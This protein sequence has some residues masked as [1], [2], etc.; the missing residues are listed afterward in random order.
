MEAD[1]GRETYCTFQFFKRR[2]RSNDSV[3]VHSFPTG[4]TR[5]V[6]LEDLCQ[7]DV[8]GDIV[9]GSIGSWVYSISGFFFFELCDAAKDQLSIH[10]SR[11][12]EEGSERKMGVLERV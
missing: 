9:K 3:A 10:S 7:L 12:D 1:Y 2:R 8:S 4:S 5:V 6:K 11:I